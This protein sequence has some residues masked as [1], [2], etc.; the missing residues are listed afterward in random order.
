[1]TYWGT[2]SLLLRAL[3]PSAE[4]V[5]GIEVGGGG[6]SGGVSSALFSTLAADRYL[7]ISFSPL[8]AYLRAL[9]ARTL[10]VCKTGGEKVACAL[11][12]FIPSSEH[13]CLEFY[14]R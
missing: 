12:M 5:C 7:L 10:M 9:K 4:V 14:R 8:D 2:F 3:P 13:V 11:L 1:M 6:G